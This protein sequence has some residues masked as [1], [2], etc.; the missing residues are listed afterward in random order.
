MKKATLTIELNGQ[1]YVNHT[2]NYRKE[3]AVKSRLESLITYY[4]KVIPH[5]SNATFTITL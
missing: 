4:R 3:S 5:Y 1:V 2:Y